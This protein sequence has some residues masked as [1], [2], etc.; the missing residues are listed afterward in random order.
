[1]L[2]LEQVALE[3]LEYKLKDLSENREVRGGVA[4]VW[5]IHHFLE[6]TQISLSDTEKLRFS[7]ASK[8]LKRLGTAPGKVK[9]ALDTFEELVLDSFSDL[10]VSTS[11]APKPFDDS[12]Q[13]G[14]E[15]SF[16]TFDNLAV[17]AFESGSS[18]QSKS[19]TLT[20]NP[21]FEKEQMTLQSLAHAVWWHDME[22][23]IQQLAVRCRVEK[24]RSMARLLYGIT[25]NMQQALE[26]PD[27][28]EEFEQQAVRIRVPI[29]DFDDPLV[30][31]SNLESLS[32]LVREVIE[33]IMNLGMKG[34]VYADLQIDRSLSLGYVKRLAYTLARDPYAGKLSALSLK[35]PSSAQIRIAIQELAKEQLREDQLKQQKL[36]LEA[37]LQSVLEQERVMR[38][39]LEQDVKRFMQSA[40]TF[41]DR[42]EP[43]LPKSIGGEA[44]DPSL[45][46]GVLFAQNPALEL[47]HIA[48]DASALTVNLSQP[49]RFVLSSNEIGL[50]RL[51]HGVTL[52]LNR[53]EYPLIDQLKLDIG[54]QKLYVFLKENYVH[55][56]LQDDSK[57][58]A[59][60]IAEAMAILFVLSSSV[61]DELLQIIKTAA[62]V[63]MGTPQALIETAVLRLRDL[64][65][66][67]PS[68]RTALDGLLRGAM[69]A[70]GLDLEENLIMGLVQRL[71]TAMTVSAEDLTVVLESADSS[72]AFVHRLSDDPISLTI[73]KQATT[74]RKYK[75]RA[76]TKSE[77]L[78]VMLPGRIVG[79]FTRNLIQPFPGGTLV[80]VRAADELAVLYFENTFIET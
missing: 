49:V 79:S 74:I 52:M 47:K 59:S 4:S 19:P 48:K 12:E 20:Q 67:A 66:K 68:R 72:Q 53:Y 38:S 54:Q 64:S 23:V 34:T 29:T 17:D 69:K 45:P 8:E 3:L 32:Q 33:I 65:S 14:L 42:L 60:N 80:C 39:M 57:S 10:S 5:D 40:E 15:L 76:E 16:E 50:T 61:R 77:S 27:F 18:Y 22:E 28:K 26:S 6:Q 73:G 7:H 2:R 71:I 1:M 35:G 11:L 21:D 75:A 46:P 70:H 30:S 37:R 41:F 36:E 62:N 56:K 43:F 9:T 31:F 44:S 58:L 55:L 13:E 25:R 51:E 63:S 78:V 24:D